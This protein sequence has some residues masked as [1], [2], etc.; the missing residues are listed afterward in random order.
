[1]EI[2]E[3][4]RNLEGVYLQTYLRGDVSSRTTFDPILWVEVCPNA[5][6]S[7]II[8]W[9]PVLEMQIVPEILFHALFPMDLDEFMLFRDEKPLLKWIEGEGV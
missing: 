2:I 8:Y 3:R 9:T 1:M 5:G 6:D 4:L 7:Y